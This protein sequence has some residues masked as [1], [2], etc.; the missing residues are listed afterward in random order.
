MKMIYLSLSLNDYGVNKDRYTGSIKYMNQ[1]GEIS[2]NLNPE[3]SDSILAIV[4]DSL[5]KASKTI[6]ETLTT[7][8][9]ETPNNPLEKTIGGEEAKKYMNGN[10]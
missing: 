9:L 8:C 7:A 4:G 6:A 1:Y 5:V 3:V 10:P 2:L